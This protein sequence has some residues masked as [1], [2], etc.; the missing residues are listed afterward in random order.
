M[1]LR[2]A[3]VSW[4][5]FKRVLVEDLWDAASK[6]DGRASLYILPET[7]SEVANMVE[8]VEMWE[9]KSIG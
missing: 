6:L 7:I 9:S 4:I 2:L 8:A 1:S 3:F 5:P